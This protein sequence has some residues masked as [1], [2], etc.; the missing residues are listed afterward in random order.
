[1][2]PVT[3]KSDPAAF[4]ADLEKLA[5]FVEKLRASGVKTFSHPAGLALTFES[6]AKAPTPG[7]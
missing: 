5:D 7:W 4:L 3:A 1:M 6:A 2:D